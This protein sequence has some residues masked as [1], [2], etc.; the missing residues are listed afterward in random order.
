MQGDSMKGKLFDAA[1]SGGGLVVAMAAD[2]MQFFIL[3]LTA[4]LLCIRIALTSLEYR[5]KKKDNKEDV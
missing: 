4:I 5:N 3:V 2:V 1:T